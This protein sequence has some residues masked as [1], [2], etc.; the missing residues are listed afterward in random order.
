MLPYQ[1][2]NPTEEFIGKIQDKALSKEMKNKYDL[3]NKSSGYDIS[4]INDPV[5]HFN[6]HILVGNIMQNFWTNEVPTPVV[7]LA[8]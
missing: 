3:V 6:V 4:S 5:V 2:K 8:T 1:G 7:S